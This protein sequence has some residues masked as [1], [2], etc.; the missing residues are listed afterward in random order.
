[1]HNNKFN[2]EKVH[3][4]EHLEIHIFLV[5]LPYKLKYICSSD[6]LHV[7]LSAFILRLQ[8]SLATRL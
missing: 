2:V 7:L 5:A 4:K 3:V 1:M 6:F 8:A